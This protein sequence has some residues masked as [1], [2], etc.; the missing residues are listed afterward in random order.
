MSPQEFEI[1]LKNNHF[2]EIATVE[3]AIGYSLGEHQH[4]FDACALVTSGD[5]TLVVNGV[6]RFYGVGDVFSLPAGMV[7]HENA[8]PAGVSYLVGRRQVTAP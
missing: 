1:D 7:H 6:P 8:G 2:G 4:P 3:R 5:I